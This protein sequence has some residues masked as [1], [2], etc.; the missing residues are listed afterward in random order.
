MKIGYDVRR[1]RNVYLASWKSIDDP[2]EG[3]FIFKLD[4]TGIPQY[5]ASK[6]SKE[7]FRLGP[8]NGQSFSGTPGLR[9]DS[10]YRF[11]YTSD[12]EWIYFLHEPIDSS[13]LS[14]TVVAVNGTWQSFKAND[15]DL[16]WN[17]TLNFVTDICDAYNRCGPYAIC[18]R[19]RSP[20]CDCLSGYMPQSQ[21]DWDLANYTQGCVRIKNCSTGDNFSKLLNIKV[22]D[23]R[24]ALGNMSWSIEKCR[25]ACV[26]NCSCTAYG[27]WYVT[28]GGAGCLLWF[29]E[30]KDITVYAENGQDIFVRGDF[31]DTGTKDGDLDLPL[32][33]M[34]TVSK[35]TSNF[36]V[37]NKLGEGG[38]GPVYKGVLQGGQEIAVKKLSQDSKQ[39]SVEFKNE[40]MCIAKLQHRNLVKLLGCCNQEEYMLIYEFMPN[41]SLDL[42]IFDDK[43]CVLLDWPK[44]LN[45]INGIARG[46]LYLHQDSRLRIIHRDLKASNVLLD[47]DMNPKISDFGMARICGGSETA[48]NT[49]RVNSIFYLCSGYMSPGYAIEGRFSFKSDVFSFGVMVLEIISGL[50][51][52][53][54]YHP[55]HHLNLLGHTWELFNQER[56]MEVIDETLKE[57]YDAAEVMQ[58]IHVGLL[59]VQESPHDRPSMGNVVLMLSSDSR[60]PPP[61]GSESSSNERIPPSHAGK[62]AVPVQG[63]KEEVTAPVAVVAR[64]NS[65]LE[66]ESLGIEGNLTSKLN[67]KILKER[68]D[69]RRK[70]KERL[71]RLKRNYVEALVKLKAAPSVPIQV[72]EVSR[73]GDVV[74]GM[75][76][77]WGKE[78]RV[79]KVTLVRSVAVVERAPLSFSRGLFL[80]FLAGYMSPEYAIEGRFSFKSDVFSFGVM[81][82]EIICGIRNR[83]FYHPDHHLN[84]LGHTWEL[85]NQERFMEAMD[86]TLKES[87]DAAEVMRAIHVSLLCVQES[88]H[89]RP[90]MGNVVLMLSSDSSRLPPPKVPG[91]FTSIKPD[92]SSGNHYFCSTNMMSI[93]LIDPR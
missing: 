44:R 47:S 25:T 62:V 80:E 12:Y 53:G 33:D 20:I 73:T 16:I 15:N 79:E 74:V 48:A 19:N 30:L 71:K 41:K 43:E 87:Y 23:S 57:S 82:I 63:V 78:Q 85:F 18:N 59:C 2:A 81:V 36:S 60:L 4:V 68:K 84:L 34:E 92:S 61:K 58:A 11:S 37:E 13:V 38:F 8:W 29:E 14:R 77:R 42:F 90:S 76:R 49:T 70:K 72:K 3:E 21:I 91:F 31:S 22:P 27:N 5:F 55:D 45:I 17:K 65:S 1:K 40:V 52:R 75:E 50:R 39:G 83:G 66:E 93:P 56:F 9:P 32:F 89:D 26:E 35:A 24:N 6:G 69:K 64:L 54:F 28:Y 67:S 7:M 46:L 88:P 86:E 10:T 51:N